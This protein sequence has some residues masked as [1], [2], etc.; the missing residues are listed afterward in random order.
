MATFEQQLV[1]AGTRWRS[2]APAIA[3]TMQVG[4][5]AD[6]PERKD[7][8]L[9][10]QLDTASGDTLWAGAEPPSTRQQFGLER[11]IGDNNLISF[12]SLQKAIAIGR[13]V[14]LVCRKDPARG[15]GREPEPIA[16]GSMVSPRLLLTNN[17]VLGSRQEAASAIVKFDYQLGEG[18]VPMATSSFDL[19]P[20]DFFATDETLDYTLVAVAPTADEGTALA[21]FGWNRLIGTEGKILKGHP[22][23]IIQHPEGG[24]KQIVLS[25]NH[26]LEL[27]EH[28][29]LYDADTLPGSS[30]AP[31]FNRQWE[32]VALHRRSVPKV[33][34][35]QIVTK[36]GQPWNAGLPPA[37][38]DWIGNEG[39]RVSSLVRHIE[40]LT[41]DGDQDRLRRE[42]MDT[43]APN[44][45]LVSHQA[46]AEGAQTVAGPRQPADTRQPIRINVPLELNVEIEVGVAIVATAGAGNPVR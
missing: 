12:D 25:G 27:F 44:P 9:R 33:V 16:T 35:G 45:F 39:T 31:V 19:R 30:G 40:S 17:H 10:H 6:T 4:P 38:I 20:D 41:L 7:A 15:P 8:F 29:F 14:G 37:S 5:V 34:N 32:V 42:M 22:V 21:H 46:L 28:Y 11:I 43:P 26:V 36:G 3:R 24:Y 1:E 18:G 2:I 13:F 23:N